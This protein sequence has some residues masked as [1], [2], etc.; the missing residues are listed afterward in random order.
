MDLF[1]ANGI[2]ASDATTRGSQPIFGFEQVQGFHPAFFGLWAR[3]NQMKSIGA[4]PR[5]D[6]AK[7]TLYR[8]RQSTFRRGVRMGRKY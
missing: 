8:S 4:D 5:D 3:R 1:A 2:G 7:E 6:N